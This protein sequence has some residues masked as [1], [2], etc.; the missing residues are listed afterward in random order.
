MIVHKG[1]V[2]CVGFGPDALVNMVTKSAVLQWLAGEPQEPLYYLFN[3]EPRK[4][5]EAAKFFDGVSVSPNGRVVCG[6]VPHRRPLSQRGV[7]AMPPRNQNADYAT[8]WGCR[9]L[10]A[11]HKRP[12]RNFRMFAP[13][14]MMD[15]DYRN[16]C[17]QVRYID[18]DQDL[19]L[20]PGGPYGDLEV[21]THIRGCSFDVSKPEGDA[22]GLA[23]IQAGD[24][25]DETPYR[26][27]YHQ[28]VLAILVGTQI[29]TTHIY[30]HATD[31]VQYLGTDGS[32]RPL[33]GDQELLGRV[34]TGPSVRLLALQGDRVLSS[35]GETIHL[36][37]TDGTHVL[38]YDFGIGEVCRG[39]FSP[40][41]LTVAA[42]G[43]EGAVLFDRDD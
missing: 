42:W 9:H 39:R 1:P 28:A 8:D 14:P 19:S 2:F 33:A 4:Y 15:A 23:V 21:Q 25:D 7:V 36:H 43:S 6:L 34:P 35:D 12:I 24:V 41:G 5:L 29:H 3:R 27:G 16:N 17:T 22:C 26:H 11:M 32:V 40:D 20:P 30:P 13:F 38:S 37:R 18:R 10:Y 31:G